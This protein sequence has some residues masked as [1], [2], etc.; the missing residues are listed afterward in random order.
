MKEVRQGS[1]RYGMDA[2]PY[3][4]CSTK[5]VGGMNEV[6]AGDSTLRL[7]AER[8]RVALTEATASVFIMR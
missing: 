5:R 3:L 4:F 2:S 7:T 8:F 1:A 6:D